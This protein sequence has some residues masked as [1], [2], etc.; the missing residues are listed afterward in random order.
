[1]EETTIY[2]LKL[3]E[4]L[5]LNKFEGIQRVVGGWLYKNYSTLDSVPVSMVF[6]PYNN[7]FSGSVNYG[8]GA[9]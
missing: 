1:M 3:H 2:T 9:K 7:E 5:F 8:T 6:V 4:E